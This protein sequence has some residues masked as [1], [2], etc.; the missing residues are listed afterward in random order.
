[1][2]NGH[3]RPQRCY[4]GCGGVPDSLS[5][6]IKETSNRY[7]PKCH[8]ALASAGL[9]RHYDFLGGK[10]AHT[11]EI[12]PRAREAEHSSAG[13]DGVT[14]NETS[15][16]IID[17]NGQAVGTLNKN[18]AINDT[19]GDEGLHR[20]DILSGVVATFFFNTHDVI[21]APDIGIAVGFV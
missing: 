3:T 10:A 2:K 15:G 14:C 20:A 8:I 12:E 5:D 6:T 4:D 7:S 16:S 13:V 19:D 17:G 21:V 9:S 18:G 1:M 11:D